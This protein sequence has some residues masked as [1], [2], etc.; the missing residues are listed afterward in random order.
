MEA[1]LREAALGHPRVLRVPAPIVRFERITPTGLDFELFVF[2]SRLEDRLVVTN[3]LNQA[4]LTK[5]IEGGILDPK[6]VPTFKVQTIATQLDARP[7]DGQ[8]AEAKSGDTKT[9]SK[10]G[11]AAAPA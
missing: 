7:A 11:D 5:M 8:A 4:I 1:V 2:V 6:P 9:A 3:D 10:D